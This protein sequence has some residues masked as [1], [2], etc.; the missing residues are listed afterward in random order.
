MGVRVRQKGGKWYVFINHHGQ[1][2]AKCVG[3][4]KKAAEAVRTKLEARLTL[5]DLG[6]LDAA[7]HVLLFRD[8]AS[9]G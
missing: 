5:G 3:D 6:I 9:A 4:S 8:Y 1:R 2:K 7:P